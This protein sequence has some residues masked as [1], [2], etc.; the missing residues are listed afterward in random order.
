AVG[1]AIKAYI[2]DAGGTASAQLVGGIIT[3]VPAPF[4]ASFSARGP[5]LATGDLLKPDLTAPGVDVLAGTSPFRIFGNGGSS[6][7]F[8]S[9]T[10]V[11]SP[12]VAGVAA[13]LKD[14]HPD[15]TPMMIKSALMTTASQI[16]G[17]GSDAT[18]FAQGA[19]H[20]TPNKAADPGLVYD[21]GFN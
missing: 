19:G 17:S 20:I 9:G 21:A 15:W 12:H 13:L 11:S 1:A 14:L 4:I 2:D 5:L 10:S 3:S 6:L 18:P 8:G 16:L 7:V